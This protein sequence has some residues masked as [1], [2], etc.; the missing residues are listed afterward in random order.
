MSP[1]LRHEVESGWTMVG[2]GGGNGNRGTIAKV[3]GGGGK[4]GQMLAVKN[5]F[6]L[7]SA[8]KK[9]D[10]TTLFSG[11]KGKKGRIVVGDSQVKGLG[12]LFCARDSE[13][14]M[15]VCLSGAGIEEVSDRLE[16][17]LVGEGDAP[18]VVISA[19]G[20]I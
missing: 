1:L 3:I 7:H 17:V 9:T 5:K 18:T 19:G 20:M 6:T 4:I 14:R 11:K 10:E 2:R 13:R 12:R 15:C 16:D 8:V